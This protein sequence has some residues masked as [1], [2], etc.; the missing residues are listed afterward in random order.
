MARGRGGMPQGGMNMNNLMKQ[1]QM[2]QRKMEETQKE[3]ETKTVEV[4]SGGGAI[5]VVMN[6]KKQLEEIVLDE[7]AVDPDDIEMLQD[8][9]ISSVNEAIRQIEELSSNEMGKLTGG[10]M[11][12]MF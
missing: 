9:I 12:G 10:M 1:A 7:S 3:L 5:K 2:M 4:T 11:P 6:G 8:L